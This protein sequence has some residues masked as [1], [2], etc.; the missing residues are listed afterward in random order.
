MSDL[1]TI[2]MSTATEAMIVIVAGT[3][4]IMRVVAIGVMASGKLRKQHRRFS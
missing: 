4:N 3:M 1:T 2:D